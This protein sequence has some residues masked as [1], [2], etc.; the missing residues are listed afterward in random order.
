M[1][2]LM[3]LVMVAWLCG[4]G[5]KSTTFEDV[6]RGVKVTDRRFFMFTAG[7]VV[8]EGTSNGITRIT[9]KAQSRADVEGI[10]AATRGLGAGLAQGLAP[11]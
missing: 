4:C 2:R 5:C 10:E 9:V 7:E 6:S 11:R 3:R 1:R 8:F